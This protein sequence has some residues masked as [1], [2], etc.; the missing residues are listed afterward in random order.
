MK[1]EHMMDKENERPEPEDS[2]YNEKNRR[3]RTIQQIRHPW[4]GF[5][6]S[7]ET[8]GQGSFHPMSPAGLLGPKV[9]RVEEIISR[10]KVHMEHV[11]DP[12]LTLRFREEARRRI[13]ISVS[14]LGQLLNLPDCIPEAAGDEYRAWVRTLV[15]AQ[16]EAKKTLWEREDLLFQWRKATGNWSAH[17]CPQCQRRG[18][19]NIGSP[20]CCK[21]HCHHVGE[22][23]LHCGNDER[24]PRD[25]KET[26]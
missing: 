2:P 5:D 12:N 26:S 21:S 18:Y 14:H 3:G 10:V 22:C 25:R 9:Y 11:A 4:V 20:A 6:P 23:C 16:P 8:W 15:E 7:C 13:E 24:D 1:G 19:E 17:R